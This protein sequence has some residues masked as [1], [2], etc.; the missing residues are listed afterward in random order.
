MNISRIVMFLSIFSFTNFFGCA[1]QNK[2]STMT[3]HELKKLMNDDSTLV[4]LDVRTPAELTGPLG[5]IDNVI[6][7]PIQEL[8]SR[9]GE[10]NKYKDKQIAV[11]CRSGNRSNTGTRLLRE[12]GFDAKNV[13]GGMIQYQKLEK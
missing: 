7:I 5:K 9:I 3:V 1:Q 4:I 11:I 2:D 10:L 8:Q 12:K 13:L 6:N